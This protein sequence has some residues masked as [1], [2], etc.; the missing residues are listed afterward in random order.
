MLTTKAIEGLQAT[1][2]QFEMTDGRVPGLR[3]RVSQDGTKTFVLLYRHRG[4]RRRQRL[5]RF[6]EMGL[7]EA[8]D[9]A[10]AVINEARSGS[11]PVAKKPVAAT[12]LTTVADLVEDFITRH[13]ERHNKPSTVRGTSRILRKDIV[14][15]WGERDARD[16]TRADVAELI[17]GIAEARSPFGASNVFRAGRTF[18]NWLVSREVIPASPFLGASDPAGIKKRDRVLTAEEIRAIWHATEQ[19]GAPWGSMIRLA[20]RD[21][22]SAGRGGRGRVARVRFRAWRLGDPGAA[23]QGLADVHQADHGVGAARARWSG[24]RPPGPAVPVIRRGECEQ[25]SVGSRR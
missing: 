19:I 7:A 14:G 13:V 10:M 18:F 6:P 1:G 23:D 22:A 20:V 12:T 8:R 15:A 9:A 5:G 3:V 21:G 24:R 17:E 25:R 4:Q 16:I 2:K 11:D